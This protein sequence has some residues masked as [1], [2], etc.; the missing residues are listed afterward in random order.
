MDLP[1]VRAQLGKRKIA[2]QGNLDPALLY[3]PPQ[4][5]HQGVR[6][7]IKRHPEPGLI[8]NLGHGVLQD[9]NVD[10][11]ATMVHAVQHESLLENL[12]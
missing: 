6:D 11:V 8:V 9:T 12:T 1:K 10:S 7:L 5:I 3:A 2:L 4:V